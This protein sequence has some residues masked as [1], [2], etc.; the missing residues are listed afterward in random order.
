MRRT[1]TIYC[2]ITTSACSEGNTRSGLSYME[3]VG[4][5]LFGIQ[6]TG[7]EVQAKLLVSE[8]GTKDPQLWR[9]CTSGEVSQ[10]LLDNERKVSRFQQCVTVMRHL[11]LSYRPCLTRVVGCR[12]PELPAHSGGEHD[13]CQHC[14][15]H[16]RLPAATTGE[17]S[18]TSQLLIKSLF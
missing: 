12:L 8:L 5:W 16:R 4:K 13:N 1:A 11:D 3:V 18:V 2:Y 7:G 9:R 17:C 14:H 10:T 6:R 15:L